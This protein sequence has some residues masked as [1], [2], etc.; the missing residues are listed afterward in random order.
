MINWDECLP[1]SDMKAE[2]E[3][4]KSL[5]PEERKNFKKE[6]QDKYSKLSEAEKTVYKEASEAGLKATIE[7]CND[8]ISRADEAILRD[9]LGE[10]PE[11]ISFSYIAKKYFGKSRNWLYQRINGYNVNGKKARFT[12]NEFQTFQN[13]LK[14]ISAMINQTS[15]KLG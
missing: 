9:K 11:A 7:A 12:E 6:M 4:F 5:S 8:F 2:F 3:R 1:T 15:L 13:A 14:D 10:L